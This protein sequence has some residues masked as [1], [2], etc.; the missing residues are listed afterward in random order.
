MS[1]NA[2]GL[3]RAYKREEIEQK[4]L[5]KGA[6]IG[7]IHETHTGSTHV[8][9]RPK[10][11]WFFSGSPPSMGRATFTRVAIIIAKKSPIRSRPS[12]VH[13]TG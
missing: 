3:V 1:F 8:E 6:D 4:M 10:F 2:R 7:L 9:R 13:R 11:H 12:L 5:D